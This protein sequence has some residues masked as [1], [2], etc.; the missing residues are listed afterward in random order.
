MQWE[1]TWKD[2]IKTEIIRTDDT[3]SG[4][5]YSVTWEK[6]YQA[7]KERLEEEKGSGPEC[8]HGADWPPANGFQYPGNYCRDCGEKL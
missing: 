4:T 6:V 7:F 5:K 1:I 8:K 2:V 3:K